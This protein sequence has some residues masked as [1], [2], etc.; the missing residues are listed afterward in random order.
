MVPRCRREL[1]EI[2]PIVGNLEAIPTVSSLEGVW[3]AP[4]RAVVFGV[5]G[6]GVADV[7]WMCK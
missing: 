4:A 2:F 6:F 5:S 3:P 1:A 7:Q